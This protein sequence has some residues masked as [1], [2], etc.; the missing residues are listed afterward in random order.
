MSLIISKSNRTVQIF[1]RSFAPTA[2]EMKQFMA[3][4]CRFLCI[5]QAS[6]CILH[7]DF[8]SDRAYSPSGKV[9]ATICAEEYLMIKNH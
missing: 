7:S 2:A 6:D 9:V 4:K 8:H 3:T 1:N 5:Y